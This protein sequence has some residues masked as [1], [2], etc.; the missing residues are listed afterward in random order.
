MTEHKEKSLLRQFLLHPA[1]LPEIISLEDFTDLFPRL[2]RSNPQIPVLYRE[3]QHERARTTD[4][5]DANISAEV[6]RGTAQR[7]E[8]VRGRRAEKDGQAVEI[9]EG[10]RREMDMEV[11]VYS[12]VSAETVPIRG[13]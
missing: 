5:V 6:K 4:Q 9:T 10:E 7:R 1:A 8:V 13:S 11:D 12:L 3:L 2:L